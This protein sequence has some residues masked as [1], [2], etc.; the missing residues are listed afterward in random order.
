MLSNRQYKSK[1]GVGVKS[2]ERLLFAH[3]RSDQ[4]LKQRIINL[5]ADEGA[6]VVGSPNMTR[7][8]AKYYAIVYHAEERNHPSRPEPATIMNAPR[9]SSAAVH[10]ELSSIDYAKCPG[11]DYLSPS[12]VTNPS[13]V[14]KSLRIGASQSSALFFKNGVPDD[15]ANHR[16]VNFTKVLRFKYSRNY[17]KG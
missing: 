1:I 9:F 5:R 16:P 14:E 13:R 17:A 6:A 8:L 15:T 10:K 7:I 12:Y 3:V 11:P 4:R 2:N